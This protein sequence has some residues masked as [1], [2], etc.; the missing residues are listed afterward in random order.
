M[1]LQEYVRS[2]W[3]PDRLRRYSPPRTV[4]IMY[5]ANVD[6]ASYFML[7]A[8]SQRRPAAGCYSSSSV[9]PLHLDPSPPLRVFRGPCI[10]RCMLWT[11]R[12]DLHQKAHSFGLVLPASG[13]SCTA[14]FVQ[15]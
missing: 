13:R 12:S 6:H 5:R 10:D 15:S 2:Y 11:L 7:D 9:A 1:R 3:L 14:D 8:F 4:H